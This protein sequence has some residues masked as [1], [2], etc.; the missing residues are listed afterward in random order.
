MHNFP[1]I[2]VVTP[3][4]NQAKYLEQTI[5][6]VLNQNYPNLEYIIIDGGSTDGSKD[7]IEQYADHISFSL[8]EPDRGQTEAINKGLV[9]ATGEWIAWQNSDDIY[10]PGVFRELAETAALYPE[11]GLI[12]GDMMLIDEHNKPLRCLRYTKPDYN[13][14]RAEGML[15]ANQTAFWH[16]DLQQKCGLLDE[17]FNYSFDYEWFL[18]LTRNTKGHHVSKIWGA[19]RIHEETKSNKKSQ[20][21]YEENCRI[22]FGREI[23]AWQKPW[24]K[25]RRFILMLS[26]GQFKYIFRGILRRTLRFKGSRY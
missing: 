8:S 9:K 24:F 26:Q 7:I 17:S 12:I 6:S 11:V 20:L 25:L 19:L 16:R 10:Y 18:R 1:R 4:F 22:L 23:P 13:A 2:T 3:S 5:L 15:I 21:F 14:M